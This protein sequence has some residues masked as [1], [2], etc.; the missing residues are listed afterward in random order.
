MILYDYCNILIYYVCL[1]ISC[2]DVCHLLAFPL[3]HCDNLKNKLVSF[4]KEQGDTVFFLVL[5]D[6]DDKK[7]QKTTKNVDFYC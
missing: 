7:S 2:A 1:C 3:S 5:D 6:C 4:L